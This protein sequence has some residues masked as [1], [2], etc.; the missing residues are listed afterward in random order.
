VKI[1]TIFFFAKLHGWP[2]GPVPQWNLAAPRPQ[3]A[4]LV[5]S[6]DGKPITIPS[7]LPPASGAL[8]SA[9]ALPAVAEPA[10]AVEAQ[11]QAAATWRDTP[12]PFEASASAGASAKFPLIRYRDIK[13]VLTGQWLIKGLLPS[14]GLCVVYGPPGCGK[15][16]L[17]LHAMLHA[18]AGKEYA[19]RKVRQARVVYI[20]AE[21]QGGFR[22][23]VRKAGDALGLDDTLQ[24]DLIEV[25]PNLG[26]SGGDASALIQA[27]KQQAQECDA[28]VGAI[29]LD[30]LSRTLCGADENGEG[31]ATFIENAGS[32]EQAF[33]CLVIP[34][35]HTGRD[36]DRGPRGWSGLHG[37][38]DAEW[39]VSEK[40]GKH[41][42]YISKMKD[43][44]DGLKWQFAL[45]VV[46]IGLDEDNEPVTTCI[47]DL[48][49]E[50]AKRTETAKKKAAGRQPPRSQREFEAAF[51]EALKAHGHDYRDASGATVCAVLVEQVRRYFAKRW[52]SDEIDER[53]RQQKVSATFNRALGSL[54]PS[55]RTQAE[56]NGAHD[57]VWKIS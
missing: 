30:T 13:P 54:P 33:E 6:R 44:E 49:S 21:G 46:T 27:I 32:I 4:P 43:G 15:S 10:S 9:E 19:G 36:V 24:F 5:G 52:A 51:N 34:V 42:V 41:L 38:D 37:A 22:K 57:R 55:Y 47:V 12:N 25:T 28:P 2:N 1:D 20:A 7:M 48:Q 29:V 45:K 53:K 8:S 31:M 23:R 14:R 16:F 35:H 50:P 26:I 17:T 3:I 11:P 56:A 18:A 40:E 39:A